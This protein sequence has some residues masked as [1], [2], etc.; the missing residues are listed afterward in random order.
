MQ[1][2]RFHGIAL[3]TLGVMLLGLQTMLYMTTKQVVTGQPESSTTKLEHETYP[4]PGILGLASL[5]A[6]GA[7]L[8]TR[9]LGAEPEAKNAV[10]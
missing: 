8:A 7:I 10:R 3:I 6:G 2:G 9:R 5:M 4:V 1:F